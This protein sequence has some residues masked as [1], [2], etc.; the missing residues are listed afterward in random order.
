MR[1]IEETQ[2]GWTRL[3]VAGLKALIRLEPGRIGLL[4]PG[5]LGGHESWL[6]RLKAC[7]LRLEAGIEAIWL[8][9]LIWLHR[10]EE[11]E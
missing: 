4:E 11:G 8:L 10:G 3:W 5:R 1:L 7:L 9:P 2:V 6:R